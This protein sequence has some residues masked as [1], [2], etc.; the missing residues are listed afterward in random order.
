[1][2][3]LRIRSLDCPGDRAC[4]PLHEGRTGGSVP[5]PRRVGGVP[6]SCRRHARGG[7][8][9]RLPRGTGGRGLHD[10]RAWRDHVLQRGRGRAL[11]PAP[12]PRRGMVRIVPPVLVGRQPAGARGLPDGDRPAR[13]PRRSGLHGDRR[14]AGWD[15]RRLPAL[16]DPALRQEGPA[17]RRG[18]RPGRCHRAP[19]RRGGPALDGPGA[20]AFERRQGRIPRAHLPRAADARD[21]DLRQRPAPARPVRPHPGTESDRD[22]D[23]HRRGLGAI[24][25]DHREPAPAQ[26]DAVRVRHRSSSRRS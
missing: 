22:G 16:P 21:H 3:A 9:P 1:M 17:H 5:A 24:A 7:A 26:P 8:L 20:R 15:A 19:P 10:R 11:G 12:G 6:T 2:A 14:A 13:G 18:Q 4:A 25:R 23:R